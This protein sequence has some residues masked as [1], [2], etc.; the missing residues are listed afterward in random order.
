MVLSDVVK[1]LTNFLPITRER[2]RGERERE[3]EGQR[4]RK[5]KG[6]RG[7]D[8]THLHTVRFEGTSVSFRFSFRTFSKQFGS[9]HGLVVHKRFFGRKLDWRNSFVNMT[10]GG[11]GVGWEGLAG[12]PPPRENL[13]PR[14]YTPNL[15]CLNVVGPFLTIFTYYQ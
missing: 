14:G 13:F 11:I 5:R 7:G 9:F 10:T 3:T 6:G 12:T 4:E 1:L 2:E 8:P 15:N